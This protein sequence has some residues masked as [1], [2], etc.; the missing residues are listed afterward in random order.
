M[1]LI[2]A[3]SLEETDFMKNKT[4]GKKSTDF[5]QILN[6]LLFWFPA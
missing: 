1:Q 6:G 2:N 3:S 4:F 5:K